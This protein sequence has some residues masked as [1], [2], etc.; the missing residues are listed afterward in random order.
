MHVLPVCIVTFLSISC[1]FSSCDRI[2]VSLDVPEKYDSVSTWRLVYTDCDNTPREVVMHSTETIPLDVA[3]N[4]CTPLLAYPVFDIRTASNPAPLKITTT[5]APVDRPL[6]AIYPYRCT[7][8]Y[9]DGFAA[10]ILCTLYTSCSK[11]N[12]P[13]QVQ[14]YLARFNWMRFMELCYSYKDPWLLD[15]ERIL[16]NIADGT[17]RKTDFV[18]TGKTD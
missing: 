2:M 9:A 5:Y 1:Q 14:R 16:L 6:G 17:F 13:A 3:K 15:R 18:Y 7:L 4:S 11:E 10:D 12:T 8:S